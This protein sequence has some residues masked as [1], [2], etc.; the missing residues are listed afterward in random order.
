[1]SPTDR[2]TTTG[3]VSR[4]D[5]ASADLSG[6]AKMREL[7]DGEEIVASP[8]VYDGYSLRLVE[9]LG[10]RTASTSGAGLANARL[11]QPDV[12]LMSM[13]ENVDACR[14]LVSAVSI[15][16][17]A[18][19]DNGYG[20]AL[21][22][23]YTV[24]YFEQAGISGINIEDQESPKR[25]GHMAGKRLVSP[26][27]MAS[28]IAAACDARENPD[29]VVCARTDALDVEGLDATIA[30]A[31]L[32]AAAGADMVFPDAVRGADDIQR[33]VA[34]VDC[35]ISINMGFGI[36]NRPTTP[37]L[38]MAELE[39]LGVRRVSLPRMLPAAAIAGMR[40]ALEIFRGSMHSGEP[41]DRPDLLAS[42]E[43]ITELMGYDGL[44]SL[45]DRLLGEDERRAR[46]GGEAVRDWVRSEGTGT[47]AGPRR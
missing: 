30:R 24:R 36:R 13:L 20:N 27:E 42:M 34:E 44:A 39:A 9:S 21:S 25:C 5:V 2:S 12:G 35:P 26:D 15:P 37:L 7:L 8:G 17:M 41:V 6:P 3:D 38:T 43:E 40:R 28:K 29:F 33:I 4:P 14:A 23:H 10:F 45:E 31:Q 11:A 32:Y 18:D 16:V 46:Y 1:M 47:T 19:A 22:V